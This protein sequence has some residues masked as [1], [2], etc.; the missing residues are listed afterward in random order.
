MNEIERN[1][2]EQMDHPAGFIVEKGSYPWD[3][4]L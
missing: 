1:E 3:V 4:I 2:D